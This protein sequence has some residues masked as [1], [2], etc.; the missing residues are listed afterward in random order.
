V[1]FVTV[2]GPQGWLKGRKEFQ[3]YH[4]EIHKV[5]FKD[6]V[7]RVKE[8]SVRFVRPDVAV[9]HVLWET[10]GDN[11]TASTQIGAYEQPGTSLTERPGT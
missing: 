9:A 3:P 2:L 6:S 4:A 7:W 8:T 11:V 5:F 1:D 10:K